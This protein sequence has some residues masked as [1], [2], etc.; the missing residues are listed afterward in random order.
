MKY[1][2]SIS[3]EYSEKYSDSARKPNKISCG[4]LSLLY[5]YRIFLKIIPVSPALTN[6]FYLFRRGFKSASLLTEPA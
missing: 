4:Y 2:K 3:N 6:I 1:F 5:F